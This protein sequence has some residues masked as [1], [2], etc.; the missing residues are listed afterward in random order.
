MFHAA[1][2]KTTQ[3][4]ID[5]QALILPDFSIVISPNNLQVAATAEVKVKLI[6]EEVV[7]VQ[8]IEKVQDKRVTFDQINCHE[9]YTHTAIKRVL[10]LHITP[11]C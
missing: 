7:M 11:C 3:V 4:V 8:E 1:Q 10:P 2:D 5:P 9:V 6:Q